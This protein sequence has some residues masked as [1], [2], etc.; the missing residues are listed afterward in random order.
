MLFAGSFVRFLVPEESCSFCAM[1]TNSLTTL[2][3]R[4]T[5]ND[6]VFVLLC[7]FCNSGGGL[8]KSELLF[9]LLGDKE[10]CGWLTQEWS[11]GCIG[12]R[13]PFLR[14]SFLRL[15]GFLTSS[16]FIANRDYV[17]SISDYIKC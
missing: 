7:C 2:P 13:E 10:G 1:G 12:C 15:N 11:S 6:G 8:V 9:G 14:N 3:L 16:G 5:S 17:G 4:I